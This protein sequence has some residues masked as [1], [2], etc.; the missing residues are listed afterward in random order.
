MKNDGR[1]I[2]KTGI[3]RV[4]KSDRAISR[5]FY[6][7]LAASGHRMP[8]GTDLVLHEKDDPAAI[9]LDGVALGRVVEESAKRYRTPLAI[10][11][12]DLTVEKEAMLGIL[13]IP[14]AEIATHHFHSAPTKDMFDAINSGLRKSL[15]PR[16]SA[17]NECIGYIAKNTSLIP[18][19]M[20]IGPFSLMTKLIADPISAVY[21]AGMGVTGDEEREVKAIEMALELSLRVVLRTISSQ[22]EAGA[23]MMIICE[24]AANV[25]Y[26]SPKQLKK[27]SD[28][29]ERFVMAPNRQIKALLDEFEVDLFLH[30]CGELTNEMV[31]TLASLD[32]VILSLGGSRILWEDSALVPSDVVLYGNLPTKKFFSADMSVADV[33][34]MTNELADR[35]SAD[36]HPFILGSE[37]DVLSVPGSHEAIVEKVAAFT[38]FTKR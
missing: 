27:G 22:I 37:C 6:F 16:M 11:L 10:P 28:I 21:M 35:M 15:T 2:D 7:D 9:K 8:I 12:M 25:V 36:G 26:L 32:P 1:Y 5:Q 13:G 14:P 29:F 3:G 18:C 34:R 24:P 31:S 4:K 23:K 17:N 30:D 20:S 38:Q 33:V 19:G